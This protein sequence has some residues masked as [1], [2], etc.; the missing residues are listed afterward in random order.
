MTEFLGL[1]YTYPVQVRSVDALSSRE[2]IGLKRLTTRRVAQRYEFD[3]TLEPTKNANLLSAHKSQHGIHGKFHLPAPQPI[4]SNPFTGRT[5]TGGLGASS[6]RLSSGVDDTII[7]RF[8]QF[9]S[10]NKIYQ[11]TSRSGRMIG[12]YP[13]LQFDMSGGA[14]MGTSPQMQAFYSR[15]GLQGVNFRQDGFVIFKLSVVEAL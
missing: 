11:V 2:S 13:N 12:I 8:V 4:G 10:F 5:A 15:D 1:K 14:G 9:S 7:G 6:V 3:I